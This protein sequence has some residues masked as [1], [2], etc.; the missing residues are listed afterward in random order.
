MEFH[1]TNMGR[2]VP[3][4]RCK[5]G[6]THL[7][8]LSSDKAANCTTEFREGIVRLVAGNGD[9]SSIRPRKAVIAGREG[10]SIRGELALALVNRIDN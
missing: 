3:R 9:R 4:Y 6:P 7:V 8:E 2:S 1:P 10:R 5:A